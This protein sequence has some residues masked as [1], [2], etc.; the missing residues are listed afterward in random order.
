VHDVVAFMKQANF[1]NLHYTQTIFRMLDEIKEMEAVK[2][3]Y[4]G[5]SFV[6]VSGAKRNLKAS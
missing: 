6:V 3:G 2:V 1:H 4:G 5:G